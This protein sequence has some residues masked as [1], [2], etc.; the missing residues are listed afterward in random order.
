MTQIGAQAQRAKNVLVK[1]NWPV[2]TQAGIEVNSVAISGDGKTIVAGTYNPGQQNLKVGTYAYDQ[3]GNQLL[4]DAIPAA[5]AKEGIYWVAISGD[6]MWAASGGGFHQVPLSGQRLKGYLYAYSKDVKNNQWNK[7]IVT[8]GAQMG[9]VNMVALSYDGT[10]L[11]AGADAAYV[12]QRNNN[13]VFEQI[14]KESVHV[15]EGV[16]SVP[17]VATSE[18]GGWIVY[19][20]TGGNWVVLCPNTAAI[21]VQVEGGPPPALVHVLGSS[22]YQ[23]P[24]GQYIKSIAMASGGSAFAVLASTNLVDCTL[25]YFSLDRNGQN[26]FPTQ[27]TPVWHQQLPNCNA[28]ESVAISADGSIVSAV[29]NVGNPP[30]VTGSACLFD[31]RGNLLWQKPTD[32]GPNSTSVAANGVYVTVADGYKQS[33]A[34]GSFHLYD[35]QGNEYVLNQPGTIAWSM[36]IS[37]DGSAIAAGDDAGNVYYFAQPGAGWEKM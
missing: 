15:N 29:G 37:A 31:G 12:F 13:G 34:G 20:T 32:H 36:Q 16:D 23:I 21:G 26:Y 30:K 8:E 35:A 6:G 33:V 22:S 17:V 19:G 3:N 28:G 10:Y 24:D 7:S 11:V 14:L 25:Y 9:G 2:L 18:N 1:S 4:N 5:G 27:Q